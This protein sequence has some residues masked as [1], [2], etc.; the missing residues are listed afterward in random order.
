VF[1]I[2]NCQQGLRGVSFGNFLIKQVAEDLGRE[3]PRLKAFATLSPIPGFRAWLAGLVQAPD[4]VPVHAEV[5]ALL[6]ELER[7]S[8]F[9][10]KALLS[11]LQQRLAPLCAHYLLHAK[12]DQEPVDAVARF[13]LVNGAAGAAQLAEDTSATGIRQ[14]AGMMVNYVYRPAAWSATTKPTRAIARS[15][16][17]AASNRSPRSP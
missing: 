5:G 16:H 9:E 2:T 7:P 12:Q 6:A 13:H 14:S 1:S 4:V 15:S 3:L 17:R 11:E 10:D 8:W